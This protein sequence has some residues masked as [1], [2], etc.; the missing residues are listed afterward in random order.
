LE[1]TVLWKTAALLILTLLKEHDSELQSCFTASDIY[2][3][4]VDWELLSMIKVQ[5]R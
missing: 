5:R 4:V 3:C 2:M 1:E